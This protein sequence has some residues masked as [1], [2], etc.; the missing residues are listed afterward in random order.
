MAK[1]IICSK[2]REFIVDDDVY[3]WAKEYKWQSSDKGNGCIYAKRDFKKHEMTSGKKRK[4]IELHREITNAKSGE[5]I[6]H[7]NRNTLDNRRENLRFSDKSSNGHNCGPSKNLRHKY[8][9]VYYHPTKKYWTAELSV[10]GQ[11][12]RKSFKTELEAVLWYNE[13][14]K[15]LY[16]GFA[17]LNKIDE[18]DKS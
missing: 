4:S 1:I 17:Y 12:T 16:G 9:G 15:E 13:K 7:I 14:A 8:K 18:V 10:R 11:R 5:M 3:L 6:D 2:S